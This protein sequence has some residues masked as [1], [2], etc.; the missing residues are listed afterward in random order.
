MKQTEIDKLVEEMQRGMKSWEDVYGHD[1]SPI[2]LDNKVCECGTDKAGGG[3][4]ST[5]C[6]KYKK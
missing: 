1:P 4:H 2:K 3:N 6:P 5:Y